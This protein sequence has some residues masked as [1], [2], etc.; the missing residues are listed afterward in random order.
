MQRSART[1][2]APCVLCTVLWRPNCT[3]PRNHL[4]IVR[5]NEQKMPTRCT[6]RVRATIAQDE[7]IPDADSAVGSSGLQGFGENGELDESH[8][9][10]YVTLIGRPNVGKSTLMN[11][12]VGQKL[13]IVTRKAQTTRHRILG[14][15]S[16][17]GF[18]IV[19]L[20]TPGVIWSMKTELDRKMMDSISQ[21]KTPTDW[22]R[23]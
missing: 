3:S 8:K 19:F 5:H 17:D 6:S 7:R 22:S 4:R 14:L 13:S 15:V 10:G 20:D 18:Q 12:L 21:V 16:G 23:D 2:T 1:P 9:A 11:S